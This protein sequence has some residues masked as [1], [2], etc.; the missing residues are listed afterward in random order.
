MMKILIFI[1]VVYLYIID[2][3]L[4][5]FMWALH[6][7]STWSDYDINILLLTMMRSFLICSR[8][9]GMRIRSAAARAG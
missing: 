9:L 6:L 7:Y 2:C 4:F 3:I 8:F 5:I 1:V